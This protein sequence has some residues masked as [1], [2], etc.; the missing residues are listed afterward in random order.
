MRL[1][2]NDRHIQTPARAARVM[3]RPLLAP[4][5]ALRGLRLPR[6]AGSRQSSAR[7]VRGGKLQ[8]DGASAATRERGQLQRRHP[9]TKTAPVQQPCASFTGML[10]FHVC[11][12]AHAATVRFGPV[13]QR[14][15]GTNLVAVG[16]MSPI[17]R[18]TP[19]VHARS[20]P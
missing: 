12:P 19:R 14:C 20:T 6:A 15:V 10:A 17:L 13:R 5:A 4:P 8:R 18:P 2:A 1:A 3:H 16:V 9:G 11:T 7:R